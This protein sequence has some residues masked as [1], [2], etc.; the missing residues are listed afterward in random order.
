[1]STSASVRDTSFRREPADIYQ[2]IA[3][4]TVR[5][6]LFSHLCT[7]RLGFSVGSLFQLCVSTTTDTTSLLLISSSA[8]A[9]ILRPQKVLQVN[10][11]HNSNFPHKKG[12][13]AKGMEKNV[14]LTFVWLCLYEGKQT[15]NR[16]LSPTVP[17]S[18]CIDS[19]G[20]FHTIKLLQKKLALWTA[21]R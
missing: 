4:S 7:T 2:L 1:M 16:S 19:Y 12:K 10:L 8:I 6:R 11:L 9:N 13:K 20:S 3:L 18:F 15:R 5:N 21:N 14:W 17:T